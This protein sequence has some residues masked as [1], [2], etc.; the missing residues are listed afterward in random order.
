[1]PEDA[2]YFTSAK[3]PPQ[4][5]VLPLIE[6]VEGLVRAGHEHFELDIVG[7]SSYTK[8]YEDEIQS[9]IE[10]KNLGTKVRLHGRVEDPS[11]FYRMASFHV[12]PSQYEEPFGLVV[13]EAKSHGVPSIVTPSG[14]MVELI[15]DGVTGV[16]AEG[17]TIGDLQQ[18]ILKASALTSNFETGYI[19]NDYHENFS[20]K[21]FVSQW[22]DVI[23]ALE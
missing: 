14:G 12:A 8:A 19:Q 23:E 5:G 7:G 1:M 20:R 11:E 15:E 13:I 18:A 9:L 17:K 16:I 6:A 3:S 2:D 4:K 21:A 22:N 10:S